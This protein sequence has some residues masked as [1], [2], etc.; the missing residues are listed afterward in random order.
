MKTILIPVS[1]GFVARNFLRGGFIEHLLDG[2]FKIVLLAPAEKRAYYESQFRFGGVEWGNLPSV[3]ETT[4]EKIWKFCERASV[5]TRT[6]KEMNLSYLF[7]HGSKD[8]FLIRIANFIFFTILWMLG[9]LRAYRSFFRFSYYTAKDKDFSEILEKHR[10]DVV[11]CPTLVYG[12]EY[13][14]MKEAKRRGI[15][16]IGMAASWDNFTSKTFL[17]VRPDFLFAQTKIMKR[18]AAL[19]GDFSTERISVVGV[20]QYDGHFK[21]E[22][23]VS[24]DEFFKE[25]GADTEKKTILFA[26]SGKISFDADWNALEILASAFK[27]GELSRENTQV[28]VRPYPKRKLCER[29]YARIRNDFGFLIESPV[30]R[31]GTGK[32][33]WEFDQKSIAFMRNSIVHSDIVISA[34]STF[35]VEAAIF[36]KPLIAISFG[37]KGANYWNSAER[38]FAW[39]HL[40]DLESTGGVWRARNAGEFFKAIQTY[41]HEP[42]LHTH[43]RQ[44]IAVEQAGFIDGK[45]IERVAVTLASFLFERCCSTN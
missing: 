17:R 22:G 37:P 23:V 21:R 38:L 30:E 18:D 9:H 39:N 2:G 33:S 20:P 5:P 29:E 11:F 12:G 10:P 32:D 14:L 1:N 8:I 15:K 26:F 4:K 45:S 42:H 24:R 3:S 28:L 41:L 44:R 27:R 25:I 6:I 36:N 43:E 16:T 13:A 31:I 19:Y 7:R 40:A 35:F 34:C